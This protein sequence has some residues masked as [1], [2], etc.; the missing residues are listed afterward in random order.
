MRYL[1]IENI[2]KYKISLVNASETFF[3]ISANFFENTTYL[4]KLKAH[5][6]N[7]R[8]LIKYTLFC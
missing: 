1:N 4:Q 3:F 7:E 6:K 2:R 5:L 8:V